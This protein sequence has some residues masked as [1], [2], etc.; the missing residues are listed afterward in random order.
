MFY[1]AFIIPLSYLPLGV[2]YR[3]S[4]AV[5]F[6]FYYVMG[7]RRKV[8]FE[9]LRNSFPEKTDQEIESISKKFYS[10]LC[11]LIIESIKGCSMSRAEVLRR[12]R[13]TNIEV[14]NKYCEAGKS[15]TTLGAHYGNWEWVALSLPQVAKFQTY[16]IFQ[17]INNPFLDRVVKKSRERNGMKLIGKKEVAATLKEMQGRRISMG[18]I[19]DQSPARTGRNHW[20]TFLNQETA[21]T[22]GFEFFAKEYDTPVIYLNIV[23]KRRGYYEGTFYS[24]TDEPRKTREGEIAE[25]F[26]RRLE[27][28]IRGKPEHWLWSHR[29]WKV[30]RSDSAI[31]PR[32]TS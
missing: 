26:M 31:E 18:Y 23:K 19:A 27:E 13:Y 3:L 28:I 8:V 1:Y 6:F 7:Y 15:V 20:V 10:H 25:A 29:R 22:T 11:D 2:L 14:F 16:G 5:F 30:N 17:K 21:V 12:H 4:D 24:V 9:N 32:S